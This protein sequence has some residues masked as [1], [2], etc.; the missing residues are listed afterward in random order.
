MGD[1]FRP[2]LNYSEAMAAEEKD[3]YVNYLME[4]PHNAA[5]DNRAMKLGCVIF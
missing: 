3:R 4:R 1:D 2:A 5:L